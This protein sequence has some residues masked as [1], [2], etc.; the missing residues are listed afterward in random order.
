M[1]NT[2]THG[3]ANESAV[4]EGLNSSSQ[5]HGKTDLS[6]APSITGVR[7]LEN[8]EKKKEKLNSICSGTPHRRCVISPGIVRLE[9]A[10]LLRSLHNLV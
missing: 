2:V 10:L 9:T 4:T 8:Q 7:R 3:R 6:C 1:I 5:T